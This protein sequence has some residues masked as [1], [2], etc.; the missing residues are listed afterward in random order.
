MGQLLIAAENG[1]VAGVESTLA[2]IKNLK[3]KGVAMIKN[4]DDADECGKT[5]LMAAARGAGHGGE[6]FNMIIDIL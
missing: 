1:D 6:Q 4:I 5:S 3:R 2:T